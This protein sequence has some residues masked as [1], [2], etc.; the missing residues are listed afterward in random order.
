VLDL[1]LNK[2][3]GQ[4]LMAGQ[5]RQHFFAQFV[6]AGAAL[7]NRYGPL[8]RRQGNCP[9][10]EVS[11]GLPAFGIHDSPRESSRCNHASANRCSRPTVAV[12]ISSDR[13]ISSTLKPP[14]Y[15]SSRIFDLRGSMAVRPSSASFRASTSLLFSGAKLKASSMA[16]TGAPLPRFALRWRRA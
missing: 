8:T 9:L 7:L 14:K 16:V 2:A 4:R 10:E 11:D 12:E 15:R 3:A 5:E 1:L 6:V 13:A